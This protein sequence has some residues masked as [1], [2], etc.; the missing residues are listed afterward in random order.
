VLAAGLDGRLVFG[1]ELTGYEAGQDGVRLTFADGRQAEADLLVGAD[2]VGSA[3]RRQ[4]LPA[5]APADTGKRCVY[6]KTPLGPADLARLPP[7]LTPI[8]T[9]R[10]HP[11]SEVNTCWQRRIRSPHQAR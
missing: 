7:T 1:C 6:G 4:Y 8:F 9:Q 2:G 5:A 11:Q 10:I 3:V